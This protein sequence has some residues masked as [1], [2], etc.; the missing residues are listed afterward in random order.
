MSF[1]M[2]LMEAVRPVKEASAA[3]VGA[4]KERF[5]PTTQPSKLS[6]ISNEEPD[7]MFCE[8]IEVSNKLTV[9]VSVS[10]LAVI[11]T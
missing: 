8:L 9:V 10:A 2:L 3:S 1:S 6:E 5:D 4:Y 11:T 7:Q